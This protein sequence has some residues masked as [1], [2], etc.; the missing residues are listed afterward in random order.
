MGLDQY[1]YVAAKAGAYSEYWNQAYWNDEEKRF[2]A[3]IPQPREIQYW[4]KHPNLHG[5]MENLWREKGCPGT[6]PE[7]PF[8]EEGVMF[9]GVELELTW[10]D[11]DRL[12]HAVE[13]G[14]LPETQG[15]F[16]GGN[17]DEEYR[18]EDLAFIRNAKADIMLG[19]RVFYNS[20]W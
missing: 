15:F 12:K 1:A 20:S 2:E 4:R 17:S 19:A 5:W 11:L 18:E 14:L 10:D 8:D 6:A 13:N 3:D 16:F 9:N 7:S